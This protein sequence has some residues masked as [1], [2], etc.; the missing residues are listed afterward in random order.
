VAEAIAC[1]TPAVALSYSSLPEVV[2]PAGLLVTDFALIDNIYSY[3]WA[4]PKGDGYGEAVER[5]IVDPELRR[6]LGL[7]GPQ[8][9]AQFSWDTAAEQFEAILQGAEAPEPKPVPVGRR[10]SALGLVEGRA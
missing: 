6:R 5:L 10:L 8:H 9:V 4:I 3:F 7:L 2:G 1:G